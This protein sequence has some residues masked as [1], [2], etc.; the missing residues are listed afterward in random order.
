MAFD[1]NATRQVTA[2]DQPALVVKNFISPPAKN[3]HLTF[4]ESAH[5]QIFALY[6]S[7]PVNIVSQLSTVATILLRLK[8]VKK[9]I[10]VQSPLCKR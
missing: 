3:N 8:S 4:K 7:S 1:G 2:T 5:Q 10:E 6:A 9:L